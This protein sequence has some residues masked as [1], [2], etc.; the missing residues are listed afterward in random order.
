MLKRERIGI[1]TL[2]APYASR[3]HG[4]GGWLAPVSVWEIR[5]NSGAGE[6]TRT[7]DPLITKQHSH[8]SRARRKPRTTR[9]RPFSK[10][11]RLPV[12]PNA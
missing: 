9:L 6:R 12:R 3:R 1:C 4:G 7:A 10:W 8:S 11:V 5:R 2:Y